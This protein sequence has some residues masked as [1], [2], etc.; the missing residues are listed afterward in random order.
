MVKNTKGGSFHKKLARKKEDE[1]KIIK[2]NLDV[3]FEQ[4]IIVLIDK[5]IGNCFTARL[6]HCE[7]ETN[8]F[9]DKELKVLHQRGKN[10]KNIFHK[11][12]SRL[13]LVTIVTDCKLT[14][15]CIG[16]VE[17]FLEHNHINEYLKNKLINQETYNKL[18][19]FMKSN[20][21]EL[22]NNEENFFETDDNKDTSK[23]ESLVE[24]CDVDK[25]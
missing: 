16:Y 2:V 24:E 17:E 10:A 23:L 19:Q 20:I 11:T 18:K 25:I 6:I 13:A 3:N 1:A 22:E 14:S 15:N 21:V 9:K 8:N 7:D 5:N 12:S 4:D